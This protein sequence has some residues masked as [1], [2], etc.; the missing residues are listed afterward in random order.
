MAWEK[1]DELKTAD[2]RA[3]GN[4]VWVSDPEEGWVPG[5]LINET[6]VQAR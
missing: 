2:E 1:P 6:T 5:H 3:R 4:M